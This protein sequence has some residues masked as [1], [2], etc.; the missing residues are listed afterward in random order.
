MNPDG[1]LLEKLKAGDENA[2]RTVFVEYYPLLLAFAFKIIR[3]EAQAKDAV[4]NVFLK[5]FASREG[6]HVQLNL[7][8]YLLTAIRNECLNLIRKESRLQEH[9]NDVV[10]D[11]DEFFFND[12]IEQAENE[13]Q[14]YKAIK[15]LPEQCQRIFIMSRLD[16]KRNSEIADELGISIRTVETQ[17]SNAL[18]ALRKKIP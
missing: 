17:I 16:D 12:A 4:Q 10:R 6:V 2:Y 3:N 13:S 1:A 11:Q 9:H 7:R 18:K 15:S 5:M 14:I 8:S